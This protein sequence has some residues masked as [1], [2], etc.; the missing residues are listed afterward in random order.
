ME[1]GRSAAHL[2]GPGSDGTE[3]AERIPAGRGGLTELRRF[4]RLCCCIGLPSC[5]PPPDLPVDKKITTEMTPGTA[6]FRRCSR[7]PYISRAWRGTPV[8]LMSPVPQPVHS[9]PSS[10]Q[11][12]CDQPPLTMLFHKRHRSRIQS[13]TLA[14]S[15]CQQVHVSW[16]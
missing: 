8:T 9:G 6:S 15:C 11:H 10:P 1:S 2:G 13:T 7:L 3:S 14:A 12:R 4:P 16:C 5:L